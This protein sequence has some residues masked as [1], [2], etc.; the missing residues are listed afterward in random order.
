LLGVPVEQKWIVTDFSS[1][2][3]AV[4]TSITS[5]LDAGYIVGVGNQEGSTEL[6]LVEN[7][8]WS[9]LAYDTVSDSTCCNAA[10]CRILMIRNPWGTDSSY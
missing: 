7:H 1:D 2:P 8:S 3:D 4:W 5:D 9:V 10:D 6:G